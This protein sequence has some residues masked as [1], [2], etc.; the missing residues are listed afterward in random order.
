MCFFFCEGIMKFTVDNIKEFVLGAESVE[1]EGKYIK[2]DRFTQEQRI[3]LKTEEFIKK[4]YSAAGIRICFVTDAVRLN[5]EVTSEVIGSTRKYFASDILVN[6]E[7]YDSLNNFEDKSVEGNYTI[8]A[9]PLGEQKKSFELAAGEKEI[10]IVCPWS[11]CSLIKELSIEGESFVKAIASKKKYI[12]FGDSITHG[13]DCLHPINRYAHR[14][15]DLFGAE[16]Y[17]KAI[18]GEFFNPDMAAAF[19]SVKPDYITVAYGT[20]DWSKKTREYFT[21]NCKKFFDTLA[22]KYPDA[23]IFAITPIWR[24]DINEE[25]KGFSEFSFVDSYIKEVTAPYKNIVCVT[26]I[27]F[28]P[29]D[30]SLFADFYL[31][32]SDKGN[33]YYFESLKKAIKPYI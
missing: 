29:H 1:K 23:K 27:D 17:C 24:A 7:Y 3:A 26:G 31:H 30:T 14:M 16:E 12:S 32:P 25:G 22:E 6:G 20:N 4:S 11:V 28:L 9:F 5:L 21:E 2:L 33:D 13:Y 19:E 18:G 8:S 15:A 10:T